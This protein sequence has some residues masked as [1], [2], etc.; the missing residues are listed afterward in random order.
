M[1][2]LLFPLLL[3]CAAL[4]SAA[5]LPSRS[6]LQ[7][8]GTA[9]AST[10]SNTS[11]A[12]AAVNTSEVAAAVSAELRQQ[13]VDLITLKTEF[14]SEGS[15]ISVGEAYRADTLAVQVGRCEAGHPW[16]QDSSSTCTPPS[17]HPS[18]CPLQFRFAACTGT[19][20]H[21]HSG[22]ELMQAVV[23]EI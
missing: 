4:V 12:A 14:T 21:H 18:S 15:S 1:H 23:G 19:Q 22:V 17:S 3:F 11:T 6:L 20:L 10:G 2:V 8:Y 13:S 7:A 5:A 16:R 9:A